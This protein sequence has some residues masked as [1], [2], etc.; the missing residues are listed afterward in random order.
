MAKKKKG[1][2]PSGNI[3]VTAYDYTDETGKRHY[4]SF[5]APTRYEAQAMAAEWKEKR[6]AVKTRTTVADAVAGYIEI[7]TGVLSPSTICAYISYQRNYFTA[8][9]EIGKADLRTLDNVQI[10]RFVSQI[11]GKVSAKTT[12]NI[13]GLLSAAIGVYMP[14][15]NFRASLP[16]RSKPDTH[17]PTD[18]EL[19]ALLDLAGK[20]MRIAIYL[21]AFGPLRRGEICALEDTDIDRKACTVTITKSRVM[22]PGGGYVTKDTPKTYSGNRTIELPP[23]VIEEMDGIKGRIL[24]REPQ[25]ITTQFRRLVKAAGL[26]HRVRFHDLRHYAASLML[27]LKVP[28]LYAMR[29]GGWSSTQVLKGIYQDVIDLEE[30]RQTKRILKRFAKV[31]G[32]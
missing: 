10:Q 23:Y 28:D 26:P 8:D 2:L 31:S 5:T 29:R 19:R 20:E 18:E 3:R 6:R 12:K 14:D 13:S 1:Q 22:A 7:K 25:Y 17:T 32:R 11:S 9:T 27:A 4:Q 21:G 24:K 16:A 15:Y 30:K